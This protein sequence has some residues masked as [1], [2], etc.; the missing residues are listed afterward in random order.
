VGGDS[1]NFRK[2]DTIHSMR[3]ISVNVGL[4]SAQLYE[5]RKVITGGAKQPVPR[6]M[7]RFGNF[8][9]DRQAD[10]VNH[11]GLEKAVCVYPFD[12]YPY[13]NRQLGRDLKPGA[14]S[15][16]L[17]VSGAIETE[18]CVGDVFWI[19]EAMVQVSQPRMP[20]AKLAGKNWSKMLPKL[21]AN[22]GYTGF[23]M[24]VLS[25]GLVAAGDGFDL[26]RAHPERITIAEVNSI[27]YEKSNDVALIKR[28]A[29]LAEFSEVGRTLFS[30]RLQRLKRG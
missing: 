20:C 11:G 22:V 3:I 17:T 1:A 8:D 6:A 27:I 25:E 15:E 16:N 12:H 30:Q 7:L 23:Y 4:P 5:G 9:G 26:E 29:E 18:V 24:R 19:G 14:F 28:L 13:W 2:D 21:I 10:R